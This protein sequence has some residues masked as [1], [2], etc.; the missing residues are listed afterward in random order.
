MF[1]TQKRHTFTISLSHRSAV[2]SLSGAAT[3][4]CSP[5]APHAFSCSRR[6]WFCPKMQHKHSL[7]CAK[8][9]IRD[10]FG[11]FTHTQLLLAAQTTTHAR[12]ND[13]RSRTIPLS[14][15]LPILC[16]VLFSVGLADDRTRLAALAATWKTTHTCKA[17]KPVTKHSSIPAKGWGLRSLHFF[18]D[19][20]GMM[21]RFFASSFALFNTHTHTAWPSSTEREDA[22][23]AAYQTHT[24]Q[25][26][27]WCS[28]GVEAYFVVF[29]FRCFTFLHSNTG[30]GRHC[31]GIVAPLP[32]AHLNTCFCN[33]HRTQQ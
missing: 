20:G 3:A 32:W 13:D 21:F 15:L 7:R 9:E 17:K 29:Y 28:S 14:H 27:T 11:D 5:H 10:T 2:A 12:A 31:A 16:A 4:Y 24:P 33:H 23:V 22:L 19:R 1:F 30:Q 26:R 8:P 18:F 25:K 6:R